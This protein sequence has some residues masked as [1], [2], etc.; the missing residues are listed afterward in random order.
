MLLVGVLQVVAAMATV[1]VVTASQL[2]SI[3]GKACTCSLI[4]LSRASDYMFADVV[5]YVTAGYQMSAVQV[6]EPQLTD[7]GKRLEALHKQSLQRAARWPNT[8]Q[9]SA[10]A[11]TGHTPPEYIIALPAGS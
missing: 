1:N 8:L 6:A 10:S 5:Q 9:V 3:R 7:K 4:S 11:D 2:E